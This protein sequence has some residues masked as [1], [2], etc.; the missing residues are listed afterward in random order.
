LGAEETV[1]S[2][3]GKEVV[4]GFVVDGASGKTLRFEVLFAGDGEAFRRW[5]EPYARGM[6]A[7]VLVSND[8]GSYGAAAGGLGLSQQLC[9]AHV[10]KYVSKRTNSISEQAEK[11]WGERE[12]GKLEN[13]NEDLRV[14]KELLGEFPRDGANNASERSIAKSK[15]RYKTMRGYKSMDGMKNGIALTQWLYNGQEEEHDLAEEMAA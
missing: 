7:E 3:K 4:V 15:M 9:I 10:R 12:D 11:E 8:N 6:G 5:L 1:F 13:L 2:V 14:L